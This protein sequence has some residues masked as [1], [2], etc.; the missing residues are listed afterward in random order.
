MANRSSSSPN[1]ARR[2]R[3]H[4][5][6]LILF[7]ASMLLGLA[8]SIV[9][10]PGE[11]P[12]DTPLPPAEP[13]APEITDAVPP[14]A[15]ATDAPIGMEVT[16]GGVHF[17]LNPALAAGATCETVP[18]VA[19]SDMVGPWEVGPEHIRLTLDGYVLPSTFHT[20]QIFVYPTADFASMNENAGAVIDRLRTFLTAPPATYE[21]G[22]PFLPPFNAAQML[23]AQVSF[24]DF[25]NG[26][27]VRFLSL[28]GQ[29]YRTVNSHELFYTFQGITDDDSHYVA[30]IL[31][32]S[33][34]SL[35]AD[36]DIPPEDFDAFAANFETYI[37]TTELALNAQPNESYS[38]DLSL[39]DTLVEGF[40]A[41]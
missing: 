32:V 29:A 20:P 13:T 28:Y 30:M 40:R 15:T 27:G 12:A 31:P 9:S 41:E 14:P 39:L 26:T 4:P 11:T 8:C 23:R 38:P 5:A 21:D 37:S 22:I 24:L 10:G 6:A 18:A 34:P 3:R 2:V 25:E 7:A 1:D 33:H 16:C 19:E 36:G 17:W 35:P